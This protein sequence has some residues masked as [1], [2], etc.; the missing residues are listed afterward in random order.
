M[1]RN[2]D[3]TR[4]CLDTPIERWDQL[5]R[6]KFGQHRFA[7]S[8]DMM[9]AWTHHLTREQ[10]LALEAGLGYPPGTDP[11]ARRAWS[12]VATR[13]GVDL[14]NPD[15]HPALTEAW[16]HLLDNLRHYLCGLSPGQRLAWVETLPPQFW[17]N[18]TGGDVVVSVLDPVHNEERIRDQQRLMARLRAERDAAL[19]AANEQSC[20]AYVQEWNRILRGRKEDLPQRV[21]AMLGILRVMIDRCPR[22]VVGLAVP[23][24]SFLT[25]AST[26]NRGWDAVWNRARGITAQRVAQERQSAGD[27]TVDRIVREANERQEEP[28]QEQG[29][30]WMMLG[31][32]AL[33]GVVV[34]AVLMKN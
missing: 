12:E 26:H 15:S 20:G 28:V 19:E 1:T 5:I 17:P 13:T 25:W 2:Q 18:A 31:G 16:P 11:E 21:E 6:A 24:Q 23:P 32:L 4:L 29:P 34:I 27:Q 30:P 3:I 10:G 8:G 14:R 7:I 9:E 22:E 33:A